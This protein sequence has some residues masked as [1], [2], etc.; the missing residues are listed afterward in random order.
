MNFKNLLISELRVFPINTN[1]ALSDENLT[2]AMTINEELK[3]IGYTIRPT[4]IIKLAQYDA[5]DNF[6]TNFK[7][8]LGDV[9]AKPM[10][11]N[12]PTQVMNMDEATYRWHQLIHYFSTYG[13]EQLFDITIDK[14]WLPNVEDTEKV[15]DD[16]TLLNA[17]VIELVAES[18]GATIYHYA[19][20]R[21]LSKRERMTDK[22]KMIIKECLNNLTVNDLTIMNINIPFK[23]NLID[24]FY[25]IFTADITNDAKINALHNICKHTGDVLKCIDYCLTKC[26]YHFKTSQKRLFVYL[27]ESYSEADFKNNIKITNKKGARAELVLRYLDYNTYSRSGKHKVWVSALRDNTLKTW[28]S[29]VEAMIREKELGTITKSDIEILTEIA[30]RPGNMLRML[31]Y[32]LRNG[33]K[34]NDIIEV[35]KNSASSL[36][37]QTLITNCTKFGEFAYIEPNETYTANKLKEMEDVYRICYNLLIAKFNSINTPI[38]DKKVYISLDEFDLTSSKLLCNDK[39]AEGGYIRS[40]LAYNI[41]ENITKL[42]FFVYWNDKSRV[43]VDFHAFGLNANRETVVHCG[44]NSS[45]NERGLVTSGDITHSDAAE[46]VDIDLIEA[47]DNRIK[48]VNADIDV[49]TIQDSRPNTFKNIEECYVGL[50]AVDKLGET[51]KLYNPKNCFFTHYLTSDTQ[52][53][54]YGFV[55]VYEG[56]LMFNGAS[57]RRD[58]VNGTSSIMTQT[59]FTLDIFLNILLHSQ[60]VTIVDKAEEAD[61]ILIMA[62][63]QSDKEVSLIDNNFFMD[64]N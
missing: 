27:I 11:P 58:I 25:T 57:T 33:F 51:V 23:Q 39:S 18:E 43:D 41:P 42:R 35:M 55:N 13:M 52:Y 63:P 26:K 62:K 32:L 21:I 9:K 17:K 19:Y 20:S 29:N 4:D 48:Y 28:Q 5:I 31:T 24:V 53:M 49:Y 47:S 34:A 16:T 7:D 44:W 15:E 45:F 36:S 40:G 8:S 1:N 54:N 64:L 46:Y 2:K 22:E 3:N 30:N 10:Y 56:Y 61:N 59:C 38:K 14:G 60:N 37:T 6:Y 50:M 12:F